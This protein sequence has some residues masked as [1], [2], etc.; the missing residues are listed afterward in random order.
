MK[1]NRTNKMIF[2]MVFTLVLC[3]LTFLPVSDL[4]AKSFTETKTSIKKTVTATGQYINWDGV[5]NVSQFLAPDGAFCFAYDDGKYVSVVK[6][7]RGKPVSKIGPEI[8]TKRRT[9]LFM[10]IVWL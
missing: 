2:I 1:K 4:Y 9:M 3:V 6:T 10:C 7:Q 5:S 8:S